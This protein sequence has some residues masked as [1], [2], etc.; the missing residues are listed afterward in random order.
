MITSNYN[1]TQ[2]DLYKACRFVWLLCQQYLTAFSDYK[3]NYT[4]AYI[5]ENLALINAV[6]A[7]PDHEARSLP[8]KGSRQDLLVERL[9]AKDFWKLLEGYIEKAY[10]EDAV[11]KAAMLGEAGQTYFD[12]VSGGSWAE[13]EG[14]LTA[15]VPFVQTRQ[16]VLTQKAFM[17]ASFLPRLEAHQIKF[18]TAHQMWKTEDNATTPATEAKITA[19]NDLKNRAFEVLADGKLALIKDK[20]NA[21]KFVWATI[22]TQIRSVKPTGLG[23]KVTIQDTKKGIGTASVSI[24]AL[25]LTVSCDK[26]GRYE[27]PTLTEGVY[28]LEFKAEDYQTLVVADREI[29]TG[30]KGRL[31]VELVPMMEMA[32]A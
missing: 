27:F 30:V 11:N 25:G 28:T 26:D 3:S 24:P 31:N 8:V 17:S 7:M 22:L 21:Q 6:E 32:M 4:A 5:A 19:N 23:G 1:C 20:T 16:D 18:N 14:L 9:E 15:M 12:K 10:K 29:K 2:T 13:I